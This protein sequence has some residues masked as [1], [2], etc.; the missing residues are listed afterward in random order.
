MFVID[1]PALA[2][3]RLGFVI[4]RD[5]NHYYFVLAGDI[6]YGHCQS[7]I[8]KDMNATTAAEEPTFLPNG[9]PCIWLEPPED[10]D[11]KD[12]LAKLL[13]V[14]PRAPIRLSGRKK[15]IFSADGESREL[16]EIVIMLSEDELAHCCYYCGRPEATL[17][18]EPHTDHW[19]RIGGNGYS[20]TYKC[21]DCLEEGFFTRVRKRMKKDVLYW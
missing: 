10:G 12:L 15:A 1:S 14:T 5:D 9:H 19:P 20:S 3:G 21:Y 17:G 8:F 18:R 11:I 13:D 16:V 6:F 7:R 2:G 4:A